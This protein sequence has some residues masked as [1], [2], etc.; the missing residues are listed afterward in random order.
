MGKGKIRGDAPCLSNTKHNSGHGIQGGSTHHPPS[1]PFNV[2]PPTHLP[3]HSNGNFAVLKWY[4][5]NS[6]LLIIIIII[7]IGYMC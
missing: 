7:Y 4:E 6:L 1:Y 3:T 2:Q 5:I